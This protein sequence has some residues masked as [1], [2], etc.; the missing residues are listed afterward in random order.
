MQCGH[1]RILWLQKVCLIDQ[2][3]HICA[4][5]IVPPVL[6]RQTPPPPSTN[7][8]RS[9]SW[10]NR[11]CLPR[12]CT[13][14]DSKALSCHHAKLPL[15]RNWIAAAAGAIGRLCRDRRPLSRHSSVTGIATLTHE[16]NWTDPSNGASRAVC[17]AISGGTT[18]TYLK[19]NYHM[20]HVAH[21]DILGFPNLYIWF[22]C[23]VRLGQFD[24]VF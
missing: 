3:Q 18:A 20:L 9:D 22:F 11:A 15:G 16:Q 10:R 24:L 23:K 14:R 13:W 19:K 2:Y 1:G 4:V 5:P 8:E 7:L 12:H 6:T 17:R 21:G